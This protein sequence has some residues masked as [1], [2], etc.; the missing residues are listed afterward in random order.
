MYA[1]LGRLGLLDPA[2]RGHDFQLDPSSLELVHAELARI[3]QVTDVVVD[4][5]TA[6]ELLELPLVSVETLLRQGQL[7]PVS[8][9][10]GAR[11]RYVSRASVAD[12]TRRYPS[13]PAPIQPGEPMLGVAVM[14]KTLGIT[15]PRMTQLVLTRQLTAVTHNRAQM[16]TVASAIG[17]A[18]RLGNINLVQELTVLGSAKPE[19]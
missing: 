2:A 9:P 5:P 14:R 10:T 17:Y 18:D 19:D 11:Q 13:R 16:I 3:Q 6:A 7:Q 4:L 12:Y 8:S 15:R 1:L